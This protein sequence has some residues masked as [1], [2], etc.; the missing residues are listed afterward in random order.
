MFG[1]ALIAAAAAAV[2]GYFLAPVLGAIAAGIVGTM[3]A[4]VVGYGMTIVVKAIAHTINKNKLDNGLT[5]DPKIEMKVEKEKGLEK[6]KVPEKILEEVKV[7]K[8]AQVVQEIGSEGKKHLKEE[9]VLKSTDK[10]NSSIDDKSGE[11]AKLQEKIDQLIQS[12]P[13]EHHEHLAAV[14]LKAMTG[15][16]SGDRTTIPRT[17][18]NEP[19]KFEQLVAR[20]GHGPKHDVETKIITSGDHSPTALDDGHRKFEQQE[21][22]CKR[23]I[24]EGHTDF[25][26][27]VIKR[28]KNDAHDHKAEIL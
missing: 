23:A 7:E 17:T 22:G 26:E 18:D 12:V 8:V 6:E 2:V 14:L 13:K 27:L 10:V 3:A 20:E 28:R 1:V 24:S 4:A 21:K 15:L 5:A 19:G 11:L 9:V 25:E 16:A